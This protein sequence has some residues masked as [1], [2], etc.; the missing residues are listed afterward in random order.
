MAYRIMIQ[1]MTADMGQ[2]NGDYDSSFEYQVN[3]PEELLDVIRRV[4][5]LQM[6]PHPPDADVCPP[7]LVVTLADGEQFWFMPDGGLLHCENAGGNV[8][9]EQALQLITTPGGAA[10]ARQA[11]QRQSGEQPARMAHIPPT[12]EVNFSWS[13]IDTG[14]HQPQVHFHLKQSHDADTNKVVLWITAVVLMAIGAAMTASVGG[15]GLVIVGVGLVC[16]WGARRA[17]ANRTHLARVGFDWNWN[18][19]WSLVGKETHTS[20]LTN[21][22]RIVDVIGVRRIAPGMGHE[23]FEVFDPTRHTEG[24]TILKGSRPWDLR[25]PAVNGDWLILDLDLTFHDVNELNHALHSIRGLL[26]S[27][28]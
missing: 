10:M 24:S 17:A 19:M 13:L 4:A 11:V 21:A 16:V 28:P 22:N 14:P 25:F 20:H 12:D 6:P 18:A 1:G 27:Q 23:C 3:T 2:A 8:T 7:N 15:P 9:P 26:A 5:P